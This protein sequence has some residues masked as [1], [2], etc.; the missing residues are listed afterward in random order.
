MNSLRRARIQAGG[1]RQKEFSYVIKYRFSFF[2]V[3]RVPTWIFVSPNSTIRLC[4]PSFVHSVLTWLSN[5]T[6]GWTVTRAPPG[7]PWPHECVCVTMAHLCGPLRASLY[8]PSLLWPTSSTVNAESTRALGSVSLFLCVCIYECQYT[9]GWV[10]TGQTHKKRAHTQFFMISSMDCEYSINDGWAAPGHYL[11][12]Q[13]CDIW[14]GFN[15]KSICNA[16]LQFTWCEGQQPMLGHWTIIIILKKTEGLKSHSLI[17]I[18]PEEHGR[19]LLL[20]KFKY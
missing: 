12:N 17:F 13:I 7:E 4:L 5:K 20:F 1:L 19:L 15:L 6:D 14:Y 18:T 11:L 2:F 10:L 8:L 9:R 3:L 16:I